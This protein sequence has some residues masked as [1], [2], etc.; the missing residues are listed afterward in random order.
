MN[1]KQGLEKEYA[2]YVAK[3]DDPYGRCAVR[4]GESVMKLLDEGKTPEEAE[5]GMYGHGLTGFL[6]GCAAQAVVHFHERGEEFNKFWN[7]SNGGT[8]DEKGTI[9]P[10]IV[11]IS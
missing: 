11:T 1:I 9:N 10:A 5:K 2:E 7:K 6:A 8:G 3:N 4:A